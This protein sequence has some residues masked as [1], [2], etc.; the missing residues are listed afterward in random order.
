[1]KAII[2]N[3]ATQSVECVTIPE[4]VTDD[5]VEEYLSAERGY[6]LDEIHYMTVGDNKPVPVHNADGTIITAL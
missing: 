3:Y 2:L 6:F 4:H 5:K 1:M